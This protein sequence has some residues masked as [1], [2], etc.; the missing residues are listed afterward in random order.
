MLT[1]SATANSSGNYSFANLQPGV[2]FLRQITPTGYGDSNAIPGNG[3]TKIDN[4][5]IKVDA[6]SPGGIYKARDFLDL[7]QGVGAPATSPLSLVALIGL[8]GG[9]LLWI[10]M[11]RHFATLP[12]RH[13]FYWPMR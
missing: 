7:Q 5:S 8:T 11:E 12:S 4:N 1:P 6:T 3:G 2:Y 10:A 9:L 13:K